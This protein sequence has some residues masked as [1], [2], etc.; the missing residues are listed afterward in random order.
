MREI[1]CRIYLVYLPLSQD[2]FSELSCY[3]RP[4]CQ[5]VGWQKYARVGAIALLFF[6]TEVR[7]WKP[8]PMSDT[9]V[10]GSGENPLVEHPS[11]TDTGSGKAGDI[12]GQGL[13]PRLFVLTVTRQRRKPKA[14]IAVDELSATG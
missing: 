2:L 8:L 4:M 1:Q 14:K 9:R 3:R 11:R 13:L 5:A 12:C 7:P 6:R 10:E